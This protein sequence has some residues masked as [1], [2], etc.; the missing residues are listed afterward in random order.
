MSPINSIASA[1]RSSKERQMPTNLQ[2]TST[3]LCAD[4]DPPWRQPLSAGILAHPLF[5]VL[6]PLI[7]ALL[8]ITLGVVSGLISTGLVTTALETAGTDHF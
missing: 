8:I 6:L 7:I 2:Q 1:K 5:L 3:I 4:R